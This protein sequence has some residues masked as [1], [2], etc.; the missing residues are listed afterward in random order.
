L[1][2]GVAAGGVADQ[3]LP[4]DQTLE[5]FSDLLIGSSAN[6]PG[7]VGNVEPHL[8]GMVKAF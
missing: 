3:Q 1:R 5:L 7:D 2:E 6:R 4:D 8:T